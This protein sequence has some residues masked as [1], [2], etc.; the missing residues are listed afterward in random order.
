MADLSETDSPVK[1]SADFGVV[2]VVVER[3][4]QV[5]WSIQRLR[6]VYPMVPITLISDGQHQPRY[7]RIAEV[8]GGRYQ[9][10]EK[11]KRPERGAEW[12]QRTFE[13][14]L[15]FGTPYVLKVD[16]DTRFNRPIASWPEFECFGT[17]ID[18]GTSREHIQGGVQG[19]RRTAVERIVASGICLRPEFRDVAF[20]SWDPAS[21]EEWRRGGYLST[22]QTLRRILLELDLAWGSWPEVISSFLATPPDADGYAISHAHKWM[23]LQ[24]RRT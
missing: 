11:L 24:D 9:R 17:V 22:D 6:V 19:F 10:G 13:A 16:P 14:G 7:E 1:R 23:Q 2:M 8:Y 4:D 15:E 12:W 20:W 3:P 18:A 21:T 5:E